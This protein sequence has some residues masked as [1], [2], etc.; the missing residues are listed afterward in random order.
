MNAKQLQIDAINDQ[1][2]ALKRANELMHE[3][4]GVYTNEA[5]FKFCES[6]LTQKLTGKDYVCPFASPINGMI[7]PLLMEL[8]IQMNES[9]I[10][11]LKY[12]L[13]VLGNV[14]TTSDQS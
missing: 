3:N 11:S 5:G 6:E 14:Q 12:Q 10:E 7:K 8:Y 1:I 13:K 2:Q 9:M 4:W